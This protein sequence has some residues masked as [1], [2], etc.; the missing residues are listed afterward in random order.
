MKKTQDDVPSEFKKGQWKEIVE[1]NLGKRME[2][3]F[4]WWEE[5]PIGVASIAE[6][7]RARLIGGKEVVIKIHSK[8]F[9]SALSVPHRNSKMCVN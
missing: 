3:M 1:Q 5:T 6:V 2:E 9:C 4:E 8:N 7:H